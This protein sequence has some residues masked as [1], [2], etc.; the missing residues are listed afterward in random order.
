MKLRL[1]G[2]LE[3]VE[4]GHTLNLGGPR[5]RA[6][7]AVLGLNVKHVTTID[8][9]VEAVWDESPPPSARGQVQVCI[10][11]IRK[12]FAKAGHPE[13]IKTESAGYI[14]R[15]PEEHVDSMVFADRLRTAK[16]QT[17]GKEA[18][19]TLRTALELW[20]G[21]ALA[22]LDSTLIRRAAA[23]LDEQRMGAIEEKMRLQFELGL[24]E[25]LIAELVV[26]VAQHPLRERLHYYMMLALYR[27]GRQAEAL[28]TYRR[29][30]T[31]LIDQISVE[32]GRE[33][34]ELHQAMLTR[35]PALNPPQRATMIVRA[36]LARK[37]EV[38]RP[39]PEPHQWAVPRQLPATIADFTGRTE[40]VA[41]IKSVLTGVGVA[42]F[43][44]YAMPIVAICG[45]AGIGKSTLA[46]RVAH[47]LHDVFPDG[48]LYAELRGDAAGDRTS[49]QLA[50][51]LRALGVAGNAIPDSLDERVELYRSCLAARRVL[52]VLDEV[53]DEEQ[54]RPLL[55]GSPTCAVITTSR[56]TLTGLPGAHHVDV[57]PF[58]PEN[59]T[60]M[61]TKILGPKRVMAE[62]DAVAELYRLCGGLPLA[63]RITGAR[64]AARKRWPISRLVDRLRD[65]V[66]RLD[67]L[68]HR[69]WALR[70][71]IDMTY[72][73]LD[74]PAKRLF[75]LLA[76]IQAP[77]LPSWTAASLLDTDLA[78]AEEVLERLVDAQV[79][80]VVDYPDA[81]H[82]RYRFHD[83]IRVYAR[84]QLLA[85][86]PEHARSAA[87]E[88]VLGMWLALAE[89]AH[90]MEYGGDFTVIHGGA[91]RWRPPDVDLAEIVRVPMHWWDGERTSLVAAV[92]QAAE[93]GFDE[94]CWDLALTCVTLFEAKAYFDDWRQVAE[95]AHE[96]VV[97]AGNVTGVAAMTYSMGTLHM[98]QG[99]LGQAEQN[100]RGAME[101]FE[102]Q[103]DDHGYALVL[104]NCANVDG[105]RGDHTEMIA[106]YEQAL[107]LLERVGD[108]IGAAHVMRTQ[109]KHWLPLG[110]IERARALLD[111]A[112]E[113][114][115][116]V[117]CVRVEAQVLH[118][119]A[120]LRVHT[121]ELERA[122][123]E[124]HRVLRIVRDGEDRLGEAHALYGLGVVRHHEGRLDSAE[125]TI[126]H[127][128]EL[129]RSMGERLIEGKAIYTLGE[130]ALARGNA[131]LGNR[132]IEQARR[133]F[134]ELG[135]TVWAVK[136]AMLLSD[137]HV[138]DGELAGA[139]GAER[140]GRHPHPDGSAGR[141]GC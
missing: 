134:V 57:E 60:E 36:P 9:L 74:E 101:L 25:E 127:T 97:R 73:V 119:F 6:M 39:A 104:R 69:G 90:R 126:V 130:I 96:A 2:P 85:V 40:E 23:A 47:E 62:A 131:A 125:S 84:E 70:S 120:E 68:E 22:G 81:R 107:R 56:H 32:P 116:A 5:P 63:L 45:R 109:A 106:K 136:A 64:L 10:S 93:A 51:F 79:L 115:R 141:I 112:L 30:R 28:E 19:R 59:S 111:R 29:A 33:L 114:C 66:R 128:V 113:I 27:T 43:P 117:H 21:P 49:W 14:L 78:E 3:L 133:I 129:A 94:L 18:V 110:E 24:H 46:I 58:V 50:R 61:L 48:A 87:L 75:R 122:R 108:K 52:V 4:D 20:R 118:T 37:E 83:L 132:H 35:D 124:L 103:G 8:Q 105:L 139:Q 17:D 123:Q 76:I 65:E 54:V 38:R 72:Q 31:T 89:E 137:S 1:L 11:R 102:A 7:L 88:R 135:S 13:A 92:L 12:L 140:G 95:A 121:G 71:S 41:E 80:E 26:L 44:G 91:P 42:P 67:E 15:L 138:A 98:F 55:P 86:E 77:D 16:K 99:R 100:F 53:H 82:L 34:Q